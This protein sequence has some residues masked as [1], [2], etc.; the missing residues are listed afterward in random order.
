MSL[1]VSLDLGIH[2]VSSLWDLL[3]ALKRCGW[4]WCN[5]EGKVEYLPLHDEDRCDWQ[6]R[7]MDDAAVM[8]LVVQKEAL[9]EPVGIH[10]FTKENIG[11]SLSAENVHTVVFLLSINRV[12]LGDS[13]RI[14]MTDVNWYMKHLVGK[15]VEHGVTVESI[16]FSEF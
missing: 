14:G 5:S 15:L 8:D 12:T 13:H 11:V 4:S 9:H 2:G 3:T 7:V 10:L 1:Q 16:E 6:I